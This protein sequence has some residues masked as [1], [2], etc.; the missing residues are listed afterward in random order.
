VPEVTGSWRNK[1]VADEIDAP[2]DKINDSGR[3]DGYRV[4][5][6]IGPAVVGSDWLLSVTAAVSL[7]STETSAQEALELGP[8]FATGA[9][10]QTY[11]FGDGALAW[12]MSNVSYNSIDQVPSCPCEVWVR[13][14]RILATVSIS[15]GGPIPPAT[16]SLSA[17]QL[18]LSAAERARD[19]IGGS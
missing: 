11:E 3:I 1:D 2:V 14:D 8:K 17:L 19:V 18:A 9:P 12:P 16:V 6:H 13:E 15:Q 7:Y 4:T 5:Y 10:T